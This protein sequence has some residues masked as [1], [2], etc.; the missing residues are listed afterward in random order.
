MPVTRTF[1]HNPNVPGDLQNVVAQFASEVALLDAIAL[2]GVPET[3]A[4]HTANAKKA[5]AVNTIRN[6]FQFANGV[7]L[8]GICRV[9]Y[10]PR[11][12]IHPQDGLLRIEFQ[13][14]PSAPVRVVYP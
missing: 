7:S 6:L 13:N 4:V 14:G 5:N 10:R 12:G 2:D 8:G 1:V 3:Y 9:M 11:D